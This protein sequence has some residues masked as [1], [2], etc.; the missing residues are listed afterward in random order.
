MIPINVVFD[1]VNYGVVSVGGNMRLRSLEDTVEHILHRSMPWDV[2]FTWERNL[3]ARIISEITLGPSHV[4]I[5]KPDNIHEVWHVTTPRC[6]YDTLENVL[7]DASMWEVGY[8]TELYLGSGDYGVIRGAP[9]IMRLRAASLV[10]TRYDYLELLLGYLMEVANF[11]KEIRPLIDDPN[12]YVCSNGVEEVFNT[13]HIPF[14][15]EE[16]FSSPQDLRA[17]AR[18]HCDEGGSLR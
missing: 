9:E 12:A 14:R 18:F 4:V 15:E 6:R 8:N 3:A 13:A 7:S 11:P 5:L 10:G 17:S 2:L 1:P 16:F